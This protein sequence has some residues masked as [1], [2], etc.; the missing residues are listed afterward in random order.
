MALPGAAWQ[1]HEE[2]VGRYKGDS[3]QDNSR[4]SVQNGQ[5]RNAP[6]DLPRK[7]PRTLWF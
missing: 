4:C 7:C 3:L 5:S 1:E 6:R 2:V